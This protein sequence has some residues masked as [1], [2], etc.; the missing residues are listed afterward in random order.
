MPP[1]IITKIIENAPSL[2]ISLFAL[3]VVSK[4]LWKSNEEHLEAYKERVKALEK[5]ADDCNQDRE[6]LHKK[7]AELQT[8]VIDKLTAL[9]DSK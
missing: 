4:K 5:H 8:N 7:H 2:G 9:V 1:E 3:W 6:E